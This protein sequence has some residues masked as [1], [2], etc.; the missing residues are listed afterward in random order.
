M[1][2][3][4]LFLAGALAVPTIAAA[5][6]TVA[7]VSTT[8]T[9]AILQ[10]DSPVQ[11]ACNLEVADMNRSISIA[12][13]VS[14]APK[15]GVGGSMSTATIT[16][17]TAAPHG[18]LPG[19][20]IYLE[21][22]GVDGW[23]GWQSIDSVP[24]PASLTFSSVTQG[25][26]TGGSV[27][28]LID[29]VNPVL[30]PGSNLD[31]RP[32]NLNTG[33]LM[34]GGAGGGQTASYSGAN[35]VFVIGH[36]DAPVASDGNRY[37]RA[38]QASSR[39]RYT[40]TCGS[41][42]FSGEFKTQ[43][44]PL[45]DTHNEGLPVDRGNPGQY[46][47]PTV[48]WSNQK[49]A[50]IDPVTGLRS[51][52]SSGPAGTPSSAQSFVTALDLNSA[53]TNPSGPLASW[54]GAAMFTGPCS[55]GSCALL[56]RAD[57]L[58]LGT[59]S[60]SG[61]VRSLDWVAV[62]ISNA[63]I[64]SA[65]SGDDCKIVACLTVDGV[66]CAN[67]GLEIAL[68][69][70]PATYT[71]GS[72]AL[73]DLWQGSGPPAITAVDVSQASGTVNYTASSKQ[74]TLSG[75]N[76][77]NIKWGAGSQINVAGSWY[78]IASVRNENQLTLSSGPS[79]NLSSV[80]Y[81]A[82]NFGVLVRKKTSTANTVSIGYTTFQYGSSAMGGANTI[83]EGACS[84]IFVTVG[85]VN[86][87]NCYAGTELFWIA[88]DGSDVRDLGNAVLGYPSPYFGWC[89]NPGSSSFDPL[90]G[91][92]TYCATGRASDNHEVI[93]QYQYT[94][95]HAAGTPGVQIPFCANNGNVQ[96]CIV[97]TTMADI[98]VTAP[99]FSPQYRASGFAA[100]QWFW[101]GS[102][103]VDNDIAIVANMGAQDT[104]GW[105]FIYT[106]GDRTPYGTDANSF[107]PIAAA[108][109]YQT[110]PW[111]WCVI[112]EGNAP[113]N[114]W[115][116][117]SFN[118]LSGYATTL[119]SAALNTTPGVPG[120]L[121]TCPINKFGVT[122]QNCTEI[123]VSGEPMSGGSALQPVQVGD[124]YQIDRELMRVVVKNSATDL[125]VQRGYIQGGGGYWIL[126]PHSGA[127]LV[128]SCG[129]RN[130]LGSDV[131]L[132]DYEDDPYGVN[133]AG[134]TLLP[135]PTA[136]AGHGVELNGMDINDGGGWSSQCDSSV[137]G[138]I[139]SCYQ[140]RH[141][142]VGQLYT[143]TPLFIGLNPPFAGIVGFGIPN[144]VDSHPGWCSGPTGWCLDSRVMLGNDGASGVMVGS[145]GAPFVNVTGQL[146]K[147]A[148]A[149]S[150]LNRKF[151][152]TMAYVGRSPLVDVSGPSSSIPTDA[153][154]SYEYCYALAAGECYSG[155]S[156][157]DLYVNAP[158]VSYPYC[159]YG[160]IGWQ[161]GDN[162][163]ICLGDLGTND[164]YLA[165]IGIAQQDLFG[166]LSRRIGTNYSRWNQ[167]AV[168]WVS[169]AS[170]A[171]E[172]LF[173]N[174]PWL[175]GVRT[176]N[177]VSIPPPYPASDSTPRGTFIPI[178]VQTDPPP[179]LM[180][181]DVIVEFG[182]AEN[183][184]PGSF[185]CTSR[186][187]PCVAVSGAIGSSAPF[188]YEQAETYS[189]APCPAGCAVAIPALAQHV[190][191]YRW[192]YRDAF[193]R[194]IATSGIQATATP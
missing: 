103:G 42:S 97:T 124:V 139:A 63:S 73:M 98:T 78:T 194:V 66:S 94:G 65:C 64:S 37:T 30:F 184:D 170:P 106:L 166:A 102:Y 58:T 108:S 68:T 167:M 26:S 154:G 45:G 191:Y 123:T 145:P 118:S 171:G 71:L 27:G 62:A 33:Q 95:N 188:F 114:G 173:S 130:N 82:N 126:Q 5:Q 178:R 127:T 76:A 96:P 143:S 48:Q 155:S 56:L 160:G 137:L 21:G 60:Y 120:G 142:H 6:I 168:F 50:M 92:I 40:L 8:A 16:I 111:S 15:R 1:R 141:G 131:G 34:P 93:V 75:G 83:V 117:P 25:T 175:D 13:G 90:N 43:N 134:T 162:N 128:M 122:G 77:F 152:T 18:L 165:Q 149:S 29:D 159:Y 183:G 109:S 84:Q 192:K 24:T 4:C 53:W 59:A 86:G 36:R 176:D 20:V 32:G 72:Q 19:A 190:L 57:N 107:R 79:S 80:P 87:Y 105:I 174:A 186:Q 133:A 181:N 116:S 125:W 46:A 89:G 148:G 91:D 146:W 185:H 129:C 11:Q 177:L 164:A 17:T 74:V 161:P 7:G 81:S 119:T 35:R 49:Q 99:A 150:L 121:N 69:T 151:L 70:T 88:A 144:A 52:R 135:D 23:D 157:G 110:A 51:F 163:A 54:G 41:Q 44:P 14:A 104:M 115:I 9:Q 179:G 112:H 38:L 180:V 55:S 2:T 61:A 85:G 28:V 187:E 172:V 136:G 10:Y 31:T 182:Y 39:H 113:D 156:A 132:W 138:G 67:S 169:Y 140:I 22:S 189:G 47:Y 158:Y 100:G 147:Y 193:G 101:S 12:S 3:V 153:T